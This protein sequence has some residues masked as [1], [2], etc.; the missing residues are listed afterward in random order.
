MCNTRFVVLSRAVIVTT[1]LVAGFTLP[2]PLWAQAN[3]EN[4]QPGSF[5]SGIGIVSG[6]VCN[7]SRVDLVFDNAATFQ[8]AY[9][10]ARGDT[11][12]ACGDANNGF[13]MLVNWNLLGDG[14]HTVRA[15]A[16]GVQFDEATFT[17]TTLLGEEFLSGA[18]G[19]YQLSSF[20]DAITDVIIRWEPSLQNFVIER[21]EVNAPPGVGPVG[22]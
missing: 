7:A 15:L 12:S 16:D 19:S 3:L 17:V 2:R 21:V 22:P 20:P 11:I 4:P 1:A 18:E 6:W 5:Q 8:A 13:G 9:G 14:T 10:T